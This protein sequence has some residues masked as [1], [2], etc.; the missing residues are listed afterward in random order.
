MK[1]RDERQALHENSRICCGIKPQSGIAAAPN[2]EI[3]EDG[4][5]AAPD[6][7]EFAAIS[8]VRLGLAAAPTWDEGGDDSTLVLE[9]LESAVRE[10]SPG[11]CHGHFFYTFPTFS[12]GR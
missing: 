3:T 4:P 6:G 10:M 8:S 2:P 7:Q 1:L 12:S 9:S 11:R 5:P